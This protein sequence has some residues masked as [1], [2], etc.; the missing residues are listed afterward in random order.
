MC[1]AGKEDGWEA[2]G[3]GGIRAAMGKS[4]V[5]VWVM[6]QWGIRERAQWEIRE[7]A[8]WDG[9]YAGRTETYGNEGERKRGGE[10]TNDEVAAIW[11]LTIR[12]RPILW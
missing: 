5:R 12:H 1:G 9:R 11:V 4:E 2:G 8:Q 6:A 10:P 3:A 7:G